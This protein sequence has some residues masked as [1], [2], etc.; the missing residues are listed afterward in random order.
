MWYKPVLTAIYNKL[1]I[2]NV[3]MIP[4]SFQ[5]NRSRAF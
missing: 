5:L 3:A 2:G 4:A 1:L